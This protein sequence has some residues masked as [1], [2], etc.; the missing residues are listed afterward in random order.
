[1]CIQE[2]HFS[3]NPISLKNYQS[4]YKNRQQQNIASGGVATYCHN[5]IQATSIPLTTNMEAVA[6]TVYLYNQKFTICNLYA[7]NSQN[8][9]KQELTNLL[10][11]LTEPYI[12]LGDFNAHHHIWGS[13]KIDS[14]GKDVEEFLDDN[15]N[16]SLMNDGSPTRFNQYN[17]KLTAIDLSFC[18]SKSYAT[19]KWEV[20]QNLH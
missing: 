17:G 15:P 11:Q 14:R 12:I 2:T 9:T 5:S 20:Y 1:M 19:F 18:D 3:E 6:T 4:S 16:L 7:P 10:Q 8:L 13:D